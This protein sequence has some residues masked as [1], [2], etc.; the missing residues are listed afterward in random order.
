MRNSP[1]RTP[2]PAAI[3]PP[4]GVSWTVNS[5]LAMD[6]IQTLGMIAVAPKLA[7]QGVETFRVAAQEP[8]FVQDDHAQTVARLEQLG[9]GG[10]CEVR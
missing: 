1:S 10:L 9:R 8:A 4:A 2:R 7:L 5:S 6:Q 3:R